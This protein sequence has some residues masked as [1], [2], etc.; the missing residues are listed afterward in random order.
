MPSSPTSGRERV[1]ETPN[2]RFP[3]GEALGLS[4]GLGL[5][6]RRP[7]RRTDSARIARYTGSQR[8]VSLIE[9]YLYVSEKE[10]FCYVPLCNS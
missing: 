2:E 9:T 7:K 4:I 3:Y 1:F 8:E 5:L 6:R 10:E